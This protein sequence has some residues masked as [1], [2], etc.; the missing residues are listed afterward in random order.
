MN[1]TNSN[2]INDI[3]INMNH[4]ALVESSQ[5]QYQYGFQSNITEH[6]STAI[7]TDGFTIQLCLEIIFTFD[8]SIL[9]KKIDSKKHHIN[10][11]IT[12]II[13]K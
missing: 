13:H 12:I 5:S 3:I 2:I 8:K 1:Q 11:C 6:A 9:I 10:Y 4:Q 7:Q